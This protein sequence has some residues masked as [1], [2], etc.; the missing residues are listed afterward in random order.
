MRLGCVIGVL[1]LAAG[2]GHVTRTHPTPRGGWEVEAAVGG[3]LVAVGPIIPTPMSTVG[4]RHGAF[5]R[6]DIGVHLHVT[7]AFFGITGGDIDTTWRVLDQR[8]GVPHV[9]LNGR[10]YAFNKDGDVRNYLE[11]TPS[12]SWLLGERYLSYVSG[13][14]FVQFAGGPVLFSAAIGEQV[15]FGRFALQGELR[16]Y[17][18]DYATRFVVVDWQPIAGQGG[19]GFIL[20]AS[21][22]FGGIR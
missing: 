5:G 2:C 4:V 3:P 8:G 6:G 22:Q 12:A 18:P 15:R 20:G 14:A 11:I 9:G 21:Y 19:W 17:Q 7:P 16:W 1:V 13:T 10:L